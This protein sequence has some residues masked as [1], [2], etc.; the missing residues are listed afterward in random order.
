MRI[1]F[2]GTVELSL[3]VLETMIEE[4][5]EIVGVVTSNHN[6]FN[7][8]Y[9]D[10]KTTC[11]KN[12]IPALE[13]NDINSDSSINW[14]KE[15]APDVVFCIGWSSLLQNRML[16][17]PPMGV[18]GFHPTALPKNRGRHPI[19]WALVL[20]LESTASTFFF[21]SKEADTGDIIDQKEVLI[22]SSDDA[23]SL[24]EKI[25]KVAKNQIKTI[26]LSLLSGNV[27]QIPQNNLDSNVWRKRN[28]Q[29]GQIDW[30]M[31]ALS[32]HNLVRGLTKPYIG[33]HFFYQEKKYKVW[34]SR[35]V[36]G[37][38]D[39][40][41]EPGKV[42]TFNNKIPCIMCGKNC[43]ELLEVTPIFI[44]SKGSYL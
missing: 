25:S 16:E 42:I 31:S 6:D 26:L 44:P 32:I 33:A 43:I 36:A 3:H 30:R 27:K 29:D 9:A 28:S 37:L 21:M 34:K 20:G 35:V 12:N 17:I 2:I 40:N 13:T 19:I 4:S 7:S 41:I 1:L 38:I 39:N 18:I 5:A 8:D 14:V 10:L 23:S 24:Y 15:L 22:D 11:V